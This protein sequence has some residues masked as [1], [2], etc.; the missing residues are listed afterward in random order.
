[1]SKQTPADS[2]RRMRPEAYIT[3]LF[4]LA[5]GPIAAV[6][7]RSHLPWWSQAEVYSRTNNLVSLDYLER[8]P[9]ECRSRQLLVATDRLPLFLDLDATWLARLPPEVMAKHIERRDNPTAQPAPR[10]KAKECAKG[11]RVGADGLV[12]S[13]TTL[14]LAWSVP[15]DAGAARHQLPLQSGPVFGVQRPPVLRAGSMDALRLVRREF[16]ADGLRRPPEV[17]LAATEAARR[18]S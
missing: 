3:H 16:G 18:S 5:Y 6:N 11:C 1:M 13:A 10:P 17:A 8:I 2:R 15:L 12:P 9:G 4:V 14:E 7:L